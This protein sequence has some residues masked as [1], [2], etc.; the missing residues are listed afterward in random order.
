MSAPI[1]GTPTRL[2][3]TS[4][5]ENG[6]NP[7]LAPELAGYPFS[8]RASVLLDL[9]DQ[10]IGPIGYKSLLLGRNVIELIIR[11][12]SATGC[13]SRQAEFCASDAFLGSGTTLIAA[14]RTGRRCYGLELDP[15]YVDTTIRRWQAL[16]NKSGGNAAGC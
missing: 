6:R 5:S 3:I 15:A 8:H 12:R 16:T 10:Q 4:R 13:C 2:K 11:T 9:G 1:S 7:Y 14:E